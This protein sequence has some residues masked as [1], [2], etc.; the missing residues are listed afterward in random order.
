MDGHRRPGIGDLTGTAPFRED[1]MARHDATE[2]SSMVTVHVYRAEEGGFWAEMPE[3]PGCYTQ[4][5]TMDEL[6]GNVREAVQCYIDAG[7]ADQRTTERTEKPEILQFA[8]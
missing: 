8:L 7:Y 4:G 5:E 6:K 1:R 3:Y 2:G